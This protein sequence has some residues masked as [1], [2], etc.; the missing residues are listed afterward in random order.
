MARLKPI[1][2]A[3]A[4]P[5]VLAL[6]ERLREGMMIEPN[7]FFKTMAH[8][9]G[10]LAP[11]IEFSAVMLEGGVLER[12]LKEWVI[13]QIARLHHC[14]Y[15][16]GAHKHA[17]SRALMSDAIGDLSYTGAAAPVLISAQDPQKLARLRALLTETRQAVYFAHREAFSRS[18][19]QPDVTQAIEKSNA[20]LKMV[21]MPT[22]I[23]AK[24]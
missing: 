1:E 15:V 21:A 14:E 4:S 20:V 11:L 5:A 7:N 23:P 24:E 13:L 12:R 18:A 17:L 19:E 9:P 6:Y 8:S 3:E 2:P 22:T 16:Y 10:I